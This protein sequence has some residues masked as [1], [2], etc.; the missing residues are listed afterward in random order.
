[1]GERLRERGDP[2]RFASNICISKV[3][4]VIR[5]YSLLHPFVRFVQKLLPG[6]ALFPRKLG[7]CF[8]GKL[9][10]GAGHSEVEFALRS[11]ATGAGLLLCG[12]CV[13]KRVYMSIYIYRQVCVC[14][15]QK[16]QHVKFP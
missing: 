7:Q 8:G 13:S 12:M 1:M 4:C 11:W 16:R 2:V 5:C 6:R 3:F 10:Q 14:V 15:C 9:G